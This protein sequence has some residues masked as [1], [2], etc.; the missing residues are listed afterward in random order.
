MLGNI[1]WMKEREKEELVACVEKP[2]AGEKGGKIGCGWKGR[3]N[4]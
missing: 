3:E 4:T 1:E 2:G